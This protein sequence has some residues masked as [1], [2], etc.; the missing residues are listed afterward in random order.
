MRQL[1]L[2][3]LL[4]ML[5]TCVTEVIIEPTCDGAVSADADGVDQTLADSVMLSFRTF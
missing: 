1:I 5:A 4:V 2:L 3:V